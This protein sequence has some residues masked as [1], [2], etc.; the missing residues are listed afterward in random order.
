MFY[1]IET[2]G[3]DG[4]KTGHLSDS[5]YSLAATTKLNDRRIISVISGTKSSSGEN[6]RKLKI[7]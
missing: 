6:K 5:G 3:A 4:I 2:S 1:Y 7:D